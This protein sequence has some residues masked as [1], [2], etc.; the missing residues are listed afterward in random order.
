MK[1]KKLKEKRE[2][3]GLSQ[4][5]LAKLSN[6]NPSTYAQYELGLR[7]IPYESAK[8]ISEI[9][10]IDIDDFFVPKYLTTRK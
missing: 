2:Q 8:Q 6:I 9:L 1:N 5:E 7:A 4:A 10:E 3:K